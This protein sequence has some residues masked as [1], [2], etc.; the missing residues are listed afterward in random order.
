MRPYVGADSL[1]N[2]KLLLGGS[3]A[4]V[5]VGLSHSVIDTSQ[6][7]IELTGPYILRDGFGILALVGVEIAQCR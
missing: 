1:I 7:R 6:A 5:N 4:N 3:F 2:H